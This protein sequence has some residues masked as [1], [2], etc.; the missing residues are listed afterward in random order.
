MDHSITIEQNY[1]TTVLLKQIRKKL[2]IKKVLF[3]FKC[4][5]KYFLDKIKKKKTLSRTFNYTDVILV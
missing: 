4:F 2:K 1:I 3:V 5:Y